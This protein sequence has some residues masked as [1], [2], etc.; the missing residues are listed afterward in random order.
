MAILTRRTWSQLLSELVLMG[1]G[2][3][4]SGYDTRCKHALAN[5]YM[6]LCARFHHYELDTSASFTVSTT[7]SYAAPSDLFIA[8]SIVF[9]ADTT[10]SERLVILNPSPFQ[11]IIGSRW[12][13][14]SGTPS[15]AVTKYARFGADLIFDGPKTGSVTGTIYYY[16]YPTM[17]D[18]DVAAYPEIA[19][20]WDE[21]LLELAVAKMQRKAWRPD[22]AMVNAQLLEAWLA[23]QIR[24]GTS[25]QPLTGIPGRSFSGLAMG[26]KQG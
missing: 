20:E 2:H 14:I 11:S 24:P 15:V 5:A 25:D 16:R 1:G 10:A 17:P 6:D 3:D 13:R 4:Y 26:G 18:F 8:I 7:R 19:V 9:D 22:L 12:E 21:H 23:E